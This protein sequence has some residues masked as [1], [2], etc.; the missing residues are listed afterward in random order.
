VLRCSMYRSLFGDFDFME[1]FLG[2]KN[3]LNA[4]VTAR[5]DCSLQQSDHR[6]CIFHHLDFDWAGGAVQHVRLLIPHLSVIADLVS[7]MFVAIIMESYEATKEP[8]GAFL[9]HLSLLHVV[10]ST[11]PS[12]FLSL[13]GGPDLVSM[14]EESVMKPMQESFQAFMRKLR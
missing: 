1:M 14:L 3:F 7:N 6:P 4:S 10:I 9:R 11:T 12:Q 2:C 13:E 5:V 8:G